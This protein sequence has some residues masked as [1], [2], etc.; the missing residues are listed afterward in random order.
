[1]NYSCYFLR[2]IRTILLAGHETS[3]TT[4]C[5]ILLELA[6]HPEVQTRLR[7]EIRSS[8]QAVHARGSSDLTAADLESMP[9]LTA[10]LKARGSQFLSIALPKEFSTGMP[11]FSP[12]CLPEL[13]S[14]RR[15]R[16]TPSFQAHQDK[17]W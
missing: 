6:R 7:A 10:V 8:E 3:A 16:H 17:L 5:W 12:S 1:M 2:P 15:R 14:G 13:S 9:Y 11:A 4:L